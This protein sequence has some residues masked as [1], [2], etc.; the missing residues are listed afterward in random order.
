M[1]D[2]AASFDGRNSR[3]DLVQILSAIRAINPEYRIHI[4]GGII[5]AST[6]RTMSPYRD[7]KVHLLVREAQPRMSSPSGNYDL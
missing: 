3:P 4:K 1:I 6:D 7:W 2:D 5:V